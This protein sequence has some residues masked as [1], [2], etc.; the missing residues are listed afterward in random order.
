MAA[1]NCFPSVYGGFHTIT[2]EL[3]GAATEPV[4]PTKPKILSGSFQ[5]KMANPCPGLG[6]WGNMLRVPSGP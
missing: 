6:Q 2:A 4:W 1:S 5:K 3:G